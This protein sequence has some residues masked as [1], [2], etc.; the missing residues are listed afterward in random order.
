MAV[1]CD[2]MEAIKVEAERVGVRDYARRAGVPYTTARSW[3]E[4][5]WTSKQL[6]T[7]DRLAA[8]L[9]EKAAS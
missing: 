5:G 4:R 8:V 6:V 2:T 9:P 1:I 7:L 3:A